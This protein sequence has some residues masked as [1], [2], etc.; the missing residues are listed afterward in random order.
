MR[1]PITTNL[2]PVLLLYYSVLSCSPMSFLV[3][4][5]VSAQIVAAV[6]FLGP[7]RYPFPCSPFLGWRS[8]G[9][10]APLLTEPGRTSP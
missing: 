10:S 9:P 1:D 2:V 3:N 6:L 5:F 4:Y 8:A 7:S